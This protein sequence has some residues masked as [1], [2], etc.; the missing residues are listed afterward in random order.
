D[1]VA[2]GAVAQGDLRLGVRTQPRQRR[3]LLLADLGLLLDQAVRVE[4]RRRHE[5]RGLVAGVAE[6]QAL[7]ASTHFLRLL[8]LLVGAVH[9]GGDVRRLLAEHVDDGAGVAV[10][11]DVGVVVADVVDDLAREGLDVDPRAGG[12]FAGDD[13]RTGLHQGLAGHAGALVLRQ[14]GIEDGIGDLIG[15]LVRM[16]LGDRFGGEELAGHRAISL[17][18]D[19][20]MGA[21]DTRVRPVVHCARHGV[22]ARSRVPPCRCPCRRPTASIGAMDS[23]T[24]IALGAAVAGAIAPARHRRAAMLAGAALGTLPDLD[25][26]PL[27]LLTDD[28]VVRMTV[29]RSFSHSLF[30]LPL[31]GWLLWWL[32]RRYGGGRV[33]EA[34]RRWFWAIQLALVTHP[35]LDA[36]TVYGTQ[37]WWPLTPPP[38]MWSSVFI[39]DPLYSIWLL[40]GCGVAW[41]ARAR[42]LASR[43]LLAGLALSSAYLGWSLLAKGVVDRQA[44]RSLAAMGLGDAR[45]FSVPMPFNTLLWRVV[46]MTPGGFVEGEY[47]LVAD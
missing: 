47:S 27:L 36:F 10:K 11:A 37:L 43:A 42:P 46:A 23:L 20:K 9:A 33:A 4:D 28:P 45:R 39:I 34:P 38:A 26:L 30:V 5:F 1:G 21:H 44:E 13:G 3:V 32:F 25:S 40:L 6:H 31:V 22:R 7:V 16:A 8:G 15:D 35:L 12:D 14:D 18:S 19:E 2:V 24:Q 29:H 17:Y 41:F